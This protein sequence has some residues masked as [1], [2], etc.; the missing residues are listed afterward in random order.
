[1]TDALDLFNSGVLTGEREGAV[2]PDRKLWESK[3]GGV[4]IIECPQRIPCNPC[5]T[6]CPTGAIRPF[7]DINDTPKV[8]HSL[9]TGCTLC[10][11]SCPGLACFVIDLTFSEDKALFKLPYEMLPLP[12][13]GQHVQCLNRTGEC[14]A[15]GTV[16]NV[17]Q[18]KKDRT[19][20]IHISAPKGIVSEFRTIRVVK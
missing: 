2:L 7:A 6:S 13:K 15:E 14:I 5:H 8:D 19:Y 11:A 4:V 20:V 18:P 12:E 10:V 1:M 3:K 9:C 17:T 16:E